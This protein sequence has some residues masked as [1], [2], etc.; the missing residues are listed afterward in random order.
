MKKWTKYDPVV[1]KFALKKHI[2]SYADGERDE[3]YTLGIMRN[4]TPE[5]AHDLLNKKVTQIKSWVQK[6]AP[7]YDEPTRD[8]GKGNKTPPYVRLYK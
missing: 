4:T 6:G 5:E 3:K 7:N 8:D 1:I 2:E